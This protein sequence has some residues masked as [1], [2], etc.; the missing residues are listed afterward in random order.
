MFK[1]GTTTNIAAFNATN[2]ALLWMAP[3]AEANGAD[4]LTVDGNTL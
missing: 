4:N 2:G 1:K 3:I